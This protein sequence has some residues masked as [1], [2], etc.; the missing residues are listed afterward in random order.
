MMIHAINTWEQSLIASTMFYMPFATW[1]RG[2][3]PMIA[4]R[5]MRLLIRVASTDSQ[6]K[7]L[8][9]TLVFYTTITLAWWLKILCVCATLGFSTYSLLRPWPI[10][11]YFWNKYSLLKKFLVINKNLCV[12]QKLWKSKSVIICVQNILSYEKIVTPVTY[13]GSKSLTGRWRINI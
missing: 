4:A 11:I 7:L 9:D 8:H 2:T 6:T 1:L 10:V 5:F 3:Y 13:F 12:F